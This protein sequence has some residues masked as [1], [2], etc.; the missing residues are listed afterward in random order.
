MTVTSFARRPA[1]QL[2]RLAAP[3]ALA[4][5]WISFEFLRDGDGVARLLAALYGA[6]GL[7]GQSTALLEYGLDPVVSK[8]LLAVLAIGTGIGAM[9]LFFVGLNGVVDLLG[10]RFR[11]RIRPF[12]F[13]G[14]ALAMLTIFLVFPAIATI[15]ASLT[16][17]G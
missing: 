16:E 4:L 1:P 17:R 6:V 10:G 15:I 2:G 3:G 8:L 5:F 7:A 12:V 9:W 14:P 13:V 11:E